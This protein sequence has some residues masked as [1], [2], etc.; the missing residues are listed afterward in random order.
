MSHMTHHTPC[1]MT[2]SLLHDDINVTKYSMLHDGC[3]SHPTALPQKEDLCDCCLAALSRA[4]LPASPSPRVC[5]YI[6]ETKKKYLSTKQPPLHSCHTLFQDRALHC[7][8]A[9]QDG[10]IATID[11]IALSHC[12]TMIAMAIM[13]A[14]ISIDFLHNTELKKV[15][16]ID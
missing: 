9:G 6:L 2:G 5:P 1:Y 7:N 3:A 16:S 4:Y 12:V 8:N 13:N 14:K 15:N 11:C 10:D